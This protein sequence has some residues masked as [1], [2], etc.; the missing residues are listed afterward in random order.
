MTDFGKYKNT[1]PYP[2]KPKKPRLQDQSRARAKD[3]REMADQVEEWEKKEQE[4]IAV[5]TAWREKQI[6]L[7]AKFKED[8]LRDVGLE[9]HPKAE[10]I[11]TKAWEDGHSAGR[12]EVYMRLE[13]YAE[14]VL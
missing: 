7:D 9:G 12:H 4:F 13:S 10:I 1:D 5:Y 2:E 6:R 14:I 11:W 3:Y 8:A